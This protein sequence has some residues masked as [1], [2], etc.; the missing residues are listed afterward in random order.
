[1]LAISSDVSV[2][3][4]CF[5]F[6]QGKFGKIVSVHAHAKCESAPDNIYFRLTTSARALG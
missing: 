2:C 1:M 3:L 5:G 4:I 6:V